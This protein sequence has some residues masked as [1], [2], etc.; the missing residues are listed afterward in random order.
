MSSSNTVPEQDRFHVIEIN[1]V[2][3]IT[4]VTQQRLEDLSYAIL[5]RKAL[6]YIG[7]GA[8]QR[9]VGSVAV[10]VHFAH[11]QNGDGIGAQVVATEAGTHFVVWDAPKPQST[12]TWNRYGIPQVSYEINKKPHLK[13]LAQGLVHPRHL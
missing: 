8:G 10:A 11:V 4:T 7:A 13:C 1:Q 2:V 6:P 12:H 9:L 5:T 3:L